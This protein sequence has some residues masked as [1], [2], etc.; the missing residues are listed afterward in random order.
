MQRRISRE[1]VLCWMALFAIG[2]DHK[3]PCARRH[4]CRINVSAA[5]GVSTPFGDHLEFE[6]LG[7]PD[8]RANDRQI[9]WAT[10]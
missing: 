3:Y 1:A 7:K 6:C 9:A 2:R 5:A 8:D 4:P 10:A